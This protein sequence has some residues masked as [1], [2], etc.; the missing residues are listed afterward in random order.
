MQATRR[1]EK[2]VPPREWRATKARDY[3]KDYQCGSWQR[4][5]DHSGLICPRRPAAGAS[6][7]EGSGRA[8][9]TLVDQL[10]QGAARRP[11]AHEARPITGIGLGEAVRRRMLAH[12]VQVDQGPTVVLPEQV[13]PLEITVT[14]TFADQF[15][16]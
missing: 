11:V 6:A 4:A 15:G 1:P 8:G 16:K 12:R 3:S 10:I 5:D 14:D 13:M 7:L 2:C 9:Q